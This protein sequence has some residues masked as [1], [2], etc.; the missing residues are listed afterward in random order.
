[1]YATGH[2]KRDPATGNVAVRTVFAEGEGPSMD[3]MAWIVADPDDGPH[4]APSSEVADWD[5]LYTPEVAG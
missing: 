4:H 1:M 5:D 2:V 3:R